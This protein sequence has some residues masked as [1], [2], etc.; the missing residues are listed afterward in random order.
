MYQ[1]THD[2]LSESSA[3][4]GDQIEEQRNLERKSQSFIIDFTVQR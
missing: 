3:A 1:S 4:K 2:N